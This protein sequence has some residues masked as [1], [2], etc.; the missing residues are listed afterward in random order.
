VN[1]NTGVTQSLD[2]AEVFQLMAAERRELERAYFDLARPLLEVPAGKRGKDEDQ[3]V[4][5]IGRFE[6]VADRR[7]PSQRRSPRSNRRKMGT[8]RRPHFVWPF[9]AFCGPVNENYD[10]YKSLAFSRLRALRVRGLPPP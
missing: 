6:W 9:G 10:S 4:A 1:P 3:P 2:R 7:C 5:M 8:I